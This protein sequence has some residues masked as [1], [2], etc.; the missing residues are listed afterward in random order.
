MKFKGFLAEVF[1]FPFHTKHFVT[2]CLII[3]LSVLAAANTDTQPTNDD[4]RQLIKQA[5]KLT[6]RGE[7][8]EA[9]KILRRV[10]EINPQESKAKL[11]LA[12]LLLKQ[13]RIIE[14]YDLSVEVAKAE[15]KNSYAFAVLGA[16]N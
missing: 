4:T 7:I 15:P 6:R 10:L 9:E 12:H 16:K 3:S 1:W 14:A 13:R 11:H 8:V 2:Y 5:E